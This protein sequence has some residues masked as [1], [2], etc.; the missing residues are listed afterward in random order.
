MADANQLKQAQAVYETMRGMFDARELAYEADDE[1][2]TVYSG[3][4]GDDLPVAIRMRIDPERMLIVV[5][6][7]LPFETPHARR[8]AM[9][10]AVSRVNYG[11]PDGSF[12]FDID[13]G[14]IVFRLTCCYR[15]SLVG[16]ELFE[17]MFVVSFGI[18]DQ[19]ND[20]LQKVATT[21]I[22]VE[23]IIKTIK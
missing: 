10:V 15:D 12:D 5:H 21:D 8:L 2:L 18:I 16:D 13:S 19:Y 22:S 3:A 9:S 23:E 4:K 1:K 7:L 20:V 17:Y 14:D 6:S 11:L